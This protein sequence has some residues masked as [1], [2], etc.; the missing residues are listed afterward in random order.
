MFSKYRRDKHTGHGLFAWGYLHVHHADAGDHM[1]TG[2]DIL[3][4]F[5]ERLGCKTSKHRWGVCAATWT[6]EGSL[7]LNFENFRT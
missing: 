5:R 7:N 1:P 6:L 3:M 2:E 4:D